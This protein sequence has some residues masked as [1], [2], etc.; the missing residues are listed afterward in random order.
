MIFWPFLTKMTSQPLLLCDQQL[1][2]KCCHI[3]K[4]ASRKSIPKCSHMYG[5]STLR[6]SSKL[7][8]YVILP[9]KWPIFVPTAP[10]NVTWFLRGSPYWLNLSVL[11]YHTHLGLSLYLTDVRGS[12]NNIISNVILDHFSSKWPATIDIESCMYAPTMRIRREGGPTY[13]V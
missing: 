13:V 4:W 7:S 8:L 10:K 1:S 9:S 6:S 2:P 3:Q 5:V 12:F 11:W